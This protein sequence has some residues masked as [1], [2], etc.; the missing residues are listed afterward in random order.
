MQ[1]ARFDRAIELC[2]RALDIDPSCEPIVRQL[3][4]VYRLTGAHAAAEEQYRYD[5]TQMNEDLGVSPPPLNKMW[6]AAADSGRHG[7]SWMDR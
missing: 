1:A 7:G 3:L 2:R 6:Q 5:S 4:R